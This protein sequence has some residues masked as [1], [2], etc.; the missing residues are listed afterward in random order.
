MSI[1]LLCLSN[2]SARV[3]FIWLVISIYTIRYNSLN[4]VLEVKI[5]LLLLFQHF[6]MTLW[7][8]IFSMKRNRDNCAFDKY[9]FV[10]FTKFLLEN[11]GIIIFP[12][13]E[14]HRHILLSHTFCVYVYVYV[15]VC[16]CVCVCMC[17]CVC[18][19]VYVCVIVCVYVCVGVW[20]CGWVSLSL[21]ICLFCQSKTWTLAIN[22]QLWNLETSNFSGELL[23]AC[24]LDLITLTFDFGNYWGICVS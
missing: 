14:D 9:I 20:V 10:L 8:W 4:M 15:C 5:R 21:S 13:I 7:P 2:L 22:F 11:F 24:D 18:G 16:V 12:F 17:V 6:T 1:S 3:I 19:C 23:S